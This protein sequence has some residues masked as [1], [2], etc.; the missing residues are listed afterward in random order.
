MT[1]SN[2]NVRE[3]VFRVGPLDHDATVKPPEGL[4]S[5]EDTED[6]F[7]AVP[8][9][10]SIGEL[11]WLLV[12]LVTHDSLDRVKFEACEAFGKNP[13]VVQAAEPV[14]AILK[15]PTTSLCGMVEQ[16]VRTATDPKLRGLLLVY[17]PAIMA[18]LSP[19]LEVLDKAMEHFHPFTSSGWKDTIV[20]RL[21][22][23]DS[24]FPGRKA[25]LASFIFWIALESKFPEDIGQERGGADGRQLGCVAVFDSLRNPSRW[26]K[27]AIMTGLDSFLARMLPV[28]ASAQRSMLV[29]LKKCLRLR[30]APLNP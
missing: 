5:I 28:A 29:L 22:S 13:L 15:T 2:R 3:V 25:L 19:D 30:L 16:L 17:L 1:P 21:I 6:V 11:Y 14:H 4:G 18:Q 23:L 10:R 27:L 8:H 20:F 12:F 9:V 7:A 24:E 26:T